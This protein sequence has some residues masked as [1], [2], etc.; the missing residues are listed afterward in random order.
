MHNT[1]N[2]LLVNNI[3]KYKEIEVNEYEYGKGITANFL[4]HAAEK[5]NLK[6]ERQE[7]NKITTLFYKGKEIAKMSGLRPSSTSNIAYRLCKNKFKLEKYL[8]LMQLNTLNSAY[9]T[10][11]EYHEALKY[12]KDNTLESFVIKPL[13]LAGGKG[14]QFDVKES[15]F[16]ELWD[17]AINVQKTEGVKEP[18]CVIQPFIDG[19]EVR[20][21]II[22]GRFCAALLRVPAHVVGDGERTIIELI[23]KKNAVRKTLSY[24]KNKLIKKDHTL[25]AYL[26]DSDLT[27]EYIPK[28][29]EVIMLSKISNLVHGAESIDVTNVI[30]DKIKNLA[31]N[32]AAAVPGLYSTGMDIMTED[33]RNGEGYIIEMNTSANLA[34]HYLPYKG[35]KRF[36]YHYFVRTSL[37]K[38][39]VDNNIL[40]SKNELEI[41]FEVSKFMK[42]KDEY[43][44]KALKLIEI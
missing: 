15:N 25:D 14:I 43:A 35:H 17:T 33:Y 10:E 12:V 16:K 18:S 9:F 24:F 37:I 40:L 5:F 29:D 41:W 31:I 7:E 2:T 34:M 44:C 23:D 13:N 20:V 11:K 38:Y 27:R 26:K 30:S 42:L 19:F 32:A 28:K 39:K 3:I 21:S 4:E 6:Y 22:E 36:P 8:Q 1:S